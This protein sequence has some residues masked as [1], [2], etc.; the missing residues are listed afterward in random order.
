MD[1]AKALVLGAQMVGVAK[2]ILSAAMQGEAP[3]RAEMK[4]LEFE[5]K[6]AMMCTGQGTIAEMRQAKV[7]QWLKV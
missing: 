7:W 3:L 6:T 1:A 4:T 5:L 2:P